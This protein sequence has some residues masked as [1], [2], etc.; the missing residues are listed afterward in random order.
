[1]TSQRWHI[2]SFVH[3]QIVCNQLIILQW[4]YLPSLT[5]TVVMLASLQDKA[6]LQK[7]E[8]KFILL[9]QLTVRNE[10]IAIRTRLSRLFYRCL[11]PVIYSK[12]Y[13]K[14]SSELDR[15]ICNIW[16]KHPR[17]SFLHHNLLSWW[18]TRRVCLVC[19]IC[20]FSYVIWQQ[21]KVMWLLFYLGLENIIPLNW[22]SNH[23]AGFS[24]ECG[25]GT[26][27]WNFE[28][29]WLAINALPGPN[30]NCGYC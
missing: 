17:S 30:E 3:I 12:M 14:H 7:I 1:M 19:Q 4:F 9:T 28:L 18:G 20:N 6:L 10:N 8:M 25:T 13:T 26:R 2:G 15:K 23:W 29:D 11:Y 5:E 22:F 16:W 27:D 21:F 24:L